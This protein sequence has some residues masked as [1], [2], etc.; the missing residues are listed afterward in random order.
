MNKLILAITLLCLSPFIFAQNDI[1]YDEYEVDEKPIFKECN[2]W[3]HPTDRY[4]CSEEKLAEFLNINTKSYKTIISTNITIETDGTVSDFEVLDDIEDAVLN[5]IEELV[6]NLPP[7]YPG[8][9]KGENVPVSMTINIKS[10]QE[11]YKVV[12]TMPRFY[13]E[14]CEAIEDVKE[15]KQCADKKMLQ[16]IYKN[17]KYPAEARENNIQGRVVVTFVVETDGRISNGEIIRGI[18]GGCEEEALRVINLMNE[19]HKIWIPG[20]QKG[21]AVRVQFNLPTK[22]SLSKK[23]KN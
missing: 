22:F 13:S 17:I 8:Q 21:K 14:E 20:F 6:Y 3:Q 1:I 11:I 23:I 15:K 12:E 5:K 2:Q 10:L 4:N 16:F 7:F 18:G 9:H 19:R